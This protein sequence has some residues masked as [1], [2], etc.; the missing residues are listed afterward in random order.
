[1]SKNN[2]PAPP[3]RPKQGRD[4]PQPTLTSPELK[5]KGGYQPTESKLSPKK[6]PSNPPNKGSSG[7]K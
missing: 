6:P 1:M 5:I 2:N 7:K 3:P 4:G